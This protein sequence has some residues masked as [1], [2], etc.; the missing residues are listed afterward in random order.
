MEP[1]DFEIWATAQ[2]K[3]LNTLS[4]N[5]F[6]GPFKCKYDFGTTAAVATLDYWTIDLLMLPAVKYM[7]DSTARDKSH[8][9]FFS[10][11]SLRYSCTFLYFC[12]YLI[13]FSFY[14]LFQTML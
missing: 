1:V 7:R 10:S 12:Y 13:Y 3:R 2:V 11:F 8:N 14:Y 5:G 9:V 4:E 6:N